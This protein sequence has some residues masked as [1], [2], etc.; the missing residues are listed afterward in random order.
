MDKNSIDSFLI[1][2]K[3]NV[4]IDQVVKPFVKTIDKQTLHKI[5]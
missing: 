3:T 1:L 2:V 5:K 4:S